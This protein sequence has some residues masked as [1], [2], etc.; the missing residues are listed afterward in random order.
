[1]GA[2]CHSNEAVAVEDS[3]TKIKPG[4]LKGSGDKEEQKSQHGHPEGESSEDDFEAECGK[5]ETRAEASKGAKM[6][7]SGKG[8]ILEKQ[9]VELDEEAAELFDKVAP[10]EGDEF[11]AVKP[12]LG[13]IKEP[14]P[15]PQ[16]GGN[17]AKK[18]KEQYEIDWVYGYRSEEARMNLFFN[19]KGE[20]V[21]PTAA[22]GVIYNFK[23]K[24]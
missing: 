11:M 21:Y 10:G 17:S 8:Q 7:L 18:P 5:M 20:A 6:S 14:I 19:N 2:A 12:W 24:E 16:I 13:A 1:M 15:A 9:G 4:K 22:L 23:D 3:T